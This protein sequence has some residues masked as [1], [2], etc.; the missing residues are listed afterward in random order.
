MPGQRGARRDQHWG[1]VLMLGLGP[2]LGGVSARAVDKTF[3]VRATLGAEAVD[4]LITQLTA[5]LSLARGGAVPG[6]APPAPQQ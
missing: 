5:A 1:A 6:F 4:N 2:Y 3:E